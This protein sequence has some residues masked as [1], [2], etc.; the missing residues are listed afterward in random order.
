MLASL[1][2]LGYEVPACDP[3]V[4]GNRSRHGS[5]FSCVSSDRKRSL[6]P[7]KSLD[8]TSSFTRT[9]SGGVGPR[10][11]HIAG[12]L[13]S[14]IPRSVANLEREDAEHVDEDVE[15]VVEGA[16]E[17]DAIR[18][19]D[20]PDPCKWEFE[21]DPHGVAQEEE[22]LRAAPRKIPKYSDM[23]ISYSTIPGE[24]RLLIMD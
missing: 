10:R 17:V 22:T 20:Q 8:I 15:D 11:L 16:E 12:P 9:A 21:A 3:D 5:G 18:D 6:T 7:E 23:L 4:A 2:Q 24:W 13:A 1:Y 19:V 14:K